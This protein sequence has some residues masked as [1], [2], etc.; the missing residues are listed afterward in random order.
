VPSEG[1]SPRI[2]LVTPRIEDAAALIDPLVAA[3][4]AA[5][6]AAV[7]ARFAEADEGALITRAE[8]LCPVVQQR[9]VAL[10]IDGRTDIAARTSADGAHVTGLGALEAALEILRLDRV[11]GAGGLRS[12][13]DAMVAAEAGAAYVMFGEPDPTGRQPGFDAIVERIEWWAELFEVPCVGFA[14]SLDQVAL[15]AGAG[16]DF[17]AVGDLIWD[18]NKAVARTMRAVAERLMLEPPQ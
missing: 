17:V 3:L 1:F 14:D 9:G 12:R 15:L 13:H 8:L 2:Y 16:A 11:L 5:D 18:N 10:L 7:L 6:V 4:G